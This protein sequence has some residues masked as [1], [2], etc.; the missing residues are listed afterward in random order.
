[1]HEVCIFQGPELNI[2]KCVAAASSST[3]KA[4]ASFSHIQLLLLAGSLL[5][6]DV[7]SGQ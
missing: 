7:V 6:A 4:A 1:M 2:Q 5:L 3:L